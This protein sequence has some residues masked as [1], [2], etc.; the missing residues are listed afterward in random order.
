VSVSAFREA[1]SSFA[2]GVVVVTTSAEGTDH[3]MTAT[4]F[5]S[6]SLDPMLILVC[7][8]RTARCHTALVAS[9][10][11][12]VSLMDRDGEAQARWFATRGR[13]LS[14]QFQG[15]AWTRGQLS[16]AV[17]LDSSLATIECRSTAVH[18]AGD[19]S[20]IVGE[21]TAVTTQGRNSGDAR[22]PLVHWRSD[23]YGLATEPHNE[24]D[25]R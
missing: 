14:G 24:I 8:A 7:V 3:A 22:L 2:T 21:V 13:D 19:H 10:R 9:G 12:A 17:L 6:V 1:L 11:W 16:G 5:A 15:F 18:P 4:S 20:I 25:H 23:Y